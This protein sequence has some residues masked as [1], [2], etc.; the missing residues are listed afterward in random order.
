VEIDAQKLLK[1]NPAAVP[2]HPVRASP[3]PMPRSLGQGRL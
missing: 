2:A 1:N 3:L